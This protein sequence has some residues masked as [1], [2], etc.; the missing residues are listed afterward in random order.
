[1]TAR[2]LTA[3]PVV[4]KIK[5]DLVERC[6]RLKKQGL[7]PSMSVIL[8]GDNP[9]SLTYIRNKKKVCEEI[10]AK[11]ELHQLSNDISEK[12]FLKKVADLNADP[13]VNGIIIQLPV[14]DELK[15]LNITNLVTPQKDI[16]GFHGENTQ[17]LYAG[18]T[19]QKLLLPCTPKGIVSL[20]DHYNIR[21]EGKNVVVIGRSLIVGKPMAMM[22]SNLNATVTMAHSKTKNLSELTRKADLVVSAIG[23]AKY[24]NEKFF[25]KSSQTV[26]I[27]VG[28]NIFE[29]KLCGDVD[30]EKVSPL[31]SAITPVPG[32]VGPMTV[33]SLIQNLITASENQLKG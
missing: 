32:G 31:V 1:M 26:V 4:E 14:S 25:D 29:G 10:G 23:Q 27:D 19:D 24:L 20:L 15:K 22:L 21:P 7:T 33:V 3:Q 2:L 28:M 18:S 16:D 5:K 13:K 12:D 6:E 17:N 9:A 11:F 30:F 8:V